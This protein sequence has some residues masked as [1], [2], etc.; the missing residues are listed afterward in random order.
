[1]DTPTELNGVN[2]TYDISDV[3]HVEWE[4]GNEVFTFDMPINQHIM[5]E[6]FPHR[7]QL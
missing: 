5:Y 1:M 4:R 3:W 2:V 6:E 7:P